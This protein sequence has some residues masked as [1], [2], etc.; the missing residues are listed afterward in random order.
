MPAAV[1]MFFLG[2]LTSIEF[3]QVPC[4]LPIVLC[5][6]LCLILVFIRQQVIHYLAIF[7]L[8]CSWALLHAYLHLA[9]VLPS[10]LENRPVMIE[11]Y[12]ASIP[13]QQSHAVTFDFLISK[14]EHTKQRV[15]VHL[16]CYQCPYFLHVGEHWRFIVKLRR[17]HSLANPSCYDLEK[18][19]F[20]NKL[21]AQGSVVKDNRNCRLSSSLWHSPIEQLRE[22]I[23][24][25]L[26]QQF[27]ENPFHGI[28]L[29]LT[30]G[31]TDYITPLQWRIFRATGTNHLVA[32]S[33]LH[34]GLA[35]SLF[36]KM[37][38][39]IWSRLPNAALFMPTLR[40]EALAGMASAILYSVLA[41]LSPSTSRSLIMIISFMIG[42]LWH[43]KITTARSLIFALGIIILLEPF[44]VLA[45]GFWLSFIAV[46]LLIYGMDGRLN[47][48]GVWCRWGKPQ[49]VVS[50][51]MAPTILLLFQQITLLSI[52]A[53]IIAVP[54]IS[55]LV[56]PTCLIGLATLLLSDKLGV[57][58]L[59]F[60]IVLLQGIWS[61]LEKIA[62]LSK[63]IWHYAFL[64]DQSALLTHIAA[65]ISLLPASMMCRILQCIW[66]T[67]CLT[68]SQPTLAPNTVQLMVFDV[69]QGLATFVRTQS[70]IL[71]FDTGAKLNDD[72]DMG[73]A[74]IVP[75]LRKLGIKKIDLLTVSHGDNDHIGGAQSILQSMQVTKIMTSVPE[76][77]KNEQ[78]VACNENMTWQW[79]GVTF[80]VLSPSRSANLVGN[81]ASCVL[82]VSNG[83]QGILL[84][85]DIEQ[86]AE[87]LLLQRHYKELASTIVI[88]PHH[89]SKTSS[90]SD[91]IAAVAPTY[92]IFST[93]YLNSYHHPHREVIKRYKRL[94]SRLL[95]TVSSGAITMTLFADSGKV[96]VEEYRKKYKKI[97]YA[98]EDYEIHSIF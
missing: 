60:G 90:T 85:G 49:W 9:W 23:Q 97:W 47:V 37:V 16:S 75:Y 30:V 98:L 36:S 92:A 8:G 35:A 96:A 14:I 15:K 45:I 65:Y 94:R 88:A 32:I 58:L 79:D 42:I 69:G 54:W 21:R 78:V 63:L 4:L 73:K 48:S 7:G 17:A 6:F 67:P 76:R 11:G 28:L 12:L 33:G 93:G 24:N 1:L 57:W 84:T 25:K 95:N 2:I 66:W 18:S 31:I 86:R 59:H 26:L 91:F 10:S 50:L 68:F 46:A 27:K 72:F 43:R 74:V 52:P 81:D 87:Q 19:Y 80:K 61:F 77:F 55:F 51:G 40:I 71:I 64:N 53:N 82:K 29:A 22:H 70:H 89:G 44:A 34:I 20:Q 41:G 39:V 13:I 83:K 3:K 62:Q 56:V 38:A 5:L